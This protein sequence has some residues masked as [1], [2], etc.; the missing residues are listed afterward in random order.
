MYRRSLDFARSGT[1]LAGL[2]AIDIAL[3]D[4][5]GKHLGLPIHTLLGGQKHAKI[6]PYATGLYFTRTVNL[7]SKLIDE[8][9]TY[10]KQGF[11]A[12]KMKVGLGVEQDLEHVQAIRKAIG[13]DIKLMI[14]SN[15]AFS[16]K[17]A[18]DLARKLED[19]N[20]AFFEEPVSPEYYEQYAQLRQQTSIPIAG[21]ECE[22]LRFGFR[23]LLEQ[24][25]VDIIQVSISRRAKTL[26][27][28]HNLPR[29]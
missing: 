19:Q 1:F 28:I 3:W 6:L 16:Y 11:R 2:S 5:K 27:F 22:Y 21:G 20:I 17:E 24:K 29:I 13:P 18:L 9:L 7:T 8:A 12:I 23:R 14:D 25:S 26:F 15:H 10:A 4:I